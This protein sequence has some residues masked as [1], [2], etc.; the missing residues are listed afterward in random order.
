MYRDVDILLMEKGV[1]EVLV[2]GRVVSE[3]DFDIVFIS[4]FV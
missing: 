3:I 2:G 1:M 4:W